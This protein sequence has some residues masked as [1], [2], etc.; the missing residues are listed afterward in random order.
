MP[1][2]IQTIKLRLKRDLYQVL[3]DDGQYG[4]HDNEATTDSS[5]SDEFSSIDSNT[6]QD[7]RHTGFKRYWVKHEA[8][9]SKDK[10]TIIALELKPQDTRNL[11]K[12]NIDDLAEKIRRLTIVLGH[13]QA[14]TVG[15]HPVN[16]STSSI[17]CF[18][19]GEQ[20]HLL[21]DCPETKAFVAK[22]V[23]RWSSEG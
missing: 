7:A 20:G 13:L 9:P 18:M 2:V 15:T 12:S 4:L 22:K 6:N 19:C 1:E 11:V 17:T 8:K 14:D 10:P 21:K 5:D 3:D 23:L 16:L